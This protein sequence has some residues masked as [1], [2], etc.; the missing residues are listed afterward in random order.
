[1]G[2]FEGIDILPGLQIPANELH[3]EFSR[4]TGPGGQHVN[5]VETRVTVCF[6]IDGSE[7]LD[8]SQR[9]R[10]RERLKSRISRDGILRISCED[11]RSQA[12]NREHVQKRFAEIVR[13]ALKTRK[14]RIPTKATLA[15]KRRRMDEK[16]RRGDLKRDRGN[17]WRQ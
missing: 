8:D 2:S 5:K 14:K 10:L 4:S 3:I 16:R 7:V 11:S 9:A 13:D 17:D 6:D 1:M 12:T 15:S